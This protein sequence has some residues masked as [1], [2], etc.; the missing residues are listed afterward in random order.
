MSQCVIGV[1]VHLTE[2]QC[3]RA[4]QRIQDYRTQCDVATELGISRN[5][6]RDILEMI[7]GDPELSQTMWFSSAKS[8]NCCFRWLVSDKFGSAKRIPECSKDPELMSLDKRQVLIIRSAPKLC[9]TDWEEL[10]FTLVYMGCPKSDTSRQKT[11][12]ASSWPG[13]TIDGTLYS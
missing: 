4:C 12:I 9:D 8:H 2:V 3:T 5:C 1:R 13:H 11:C 6:I 10:T 7:P